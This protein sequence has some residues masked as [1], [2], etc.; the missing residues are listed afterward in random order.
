MGI[1]MQKRNKGNE[2]ADQKKRMRRRKEKVWVAEA[3][4]VLCVIA[5]RVFAAVRYDVG[6]AGAASYA[7]AMVSGENTS[8]RSGSY[9]SDL[10]IRFL[11]VLFRFFGNKAE[12]AAFTQLILQC[13]AIF[14]FAAALKKLLGGAAAIFFLLA[15]AFAPCFLFQY[16]RCSPDLLL[17]LLLGFAFYAAGGLK[18]SVRTDKW[19]AVGPLSLITGILAGVFVWL[20]LPDL[21]NMTYASHMNLYAFVCLAAVCS[22]L[23]GVVNGF[24][25]LRAAREKK[26]EAARTDETADDKK[27]KTGDKDE[28]E[29]KEADKPRTNYIPNP[30]PLPKKHI[31]K[32]MGFDVNTDAGDRLPDFDYKG[33]EEDDFDI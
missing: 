26:R 12:I 15:A 10:Y 28:D 9:V 14:I 8:V 5:A 6:G 25:A 7:A 2:P 31:K 13:A 17:C 4:S 33:T 29:K 19:A 16:D 11:S 30:L 32:V 21:K 1:K 18:R 24:G 27:E 3:L 20:I 23:Q 22:L